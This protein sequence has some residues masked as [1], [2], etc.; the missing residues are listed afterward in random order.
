VPQQKLA[1]PMPGSGLILLGVLPGTH[2]IAQRFVR[3]VGN[4]DRRQVAASVAASQ[5]GGVAPVG[6]DPISRFGGNQRPRDHLA[7]YP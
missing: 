6:L 4:A 1:Q 7:P 5:F 3:L 2:Q